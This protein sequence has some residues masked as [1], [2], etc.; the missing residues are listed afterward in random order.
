MNTG[1]RS[2]SKRL[3]LRRPS[4]STSLVGAL[5]ALMLVGCGPATSPAFSRDAVSA[6]AVLARPVA[7]PRG[8]CAIPP[9]P[10][11]GEWPQ[12]A[13]APCELDDG[14]RVFV[15][16]S[17]RGGG[18]FVVAIDVAVPDRAWLRTSV[19]WRRQPGYVLLGCDEPDVDAPSHKATTPEAPLDRYVAEVRGDRVVVGERVVMSRDATRGIQ[20][21]KAGCISR[22]GFRSYS[23]PTVDAVKTSHGSE[24]WNM[25]AGGVALDTVAQHEGRVVV[26]DGVVMRWGRMRAQVCAAEDVIALGAA[27]KRLRGPCPAGSPIAR[28]APLLKED[29]KVN[30]ALGPFLARVRR[31]ELVD[32]VTLTGYAETAPIPP[33][34]KGA[35]RR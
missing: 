4:I 10:E 30:V 25:Y 16:H 15:Q 19:Y 1:A 11:D 32:L 14:T 26:L 6:R 33:S 23:G 2:S 34:L 27:S 29:D 21:P 13:V 24:G 35:R 3:V 8:T 12:W 22:D 31:G 18:V 20:S 28:E 9:L 17:G 7:A 5:G